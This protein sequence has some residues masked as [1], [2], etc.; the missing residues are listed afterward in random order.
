MIP[1]RAKEGY[2]FDE[3]RNQNIVADDPAL[4]DLWAWLKR[5]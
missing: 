2:L 5:K 4:R 3:A 1:P